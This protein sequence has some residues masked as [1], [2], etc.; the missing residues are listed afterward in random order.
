MNPIVTIFIILDLMGLKQNNYG[1]NFLKIISI[2]AIIFHKL[3][4][5]DLSSTFPSSFSSNNIPLQFLFFLYSSAT[6]FV[7]SHTC[8]LTNVTV[9]DF[10]RL[11][12]SAEFF[13]VGYYFGEYFFSIQKSL[14]SSKWE[15]F[16]QLHIVQTN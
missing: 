7:I 9:K 15:Y 16:F 13:S 5:S 8:P 10:F 6:L 2:F 14:S 12:F 3:L 1:M 11:W 4:Q